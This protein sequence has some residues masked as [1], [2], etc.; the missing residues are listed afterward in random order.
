[1]FYATQSVPYDINIIMY[2]LLEFDIPNKNSEDISNDCVS[3]IRKQMVPYNRRWWIFSDP[4]I[5]NY[6]YWTYEK[7][8]KK[9]QWTW[10][11]LNTLGIV[12]GKQKY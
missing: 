8:K 9:S 6:I 2:L 3:S 4:Y 5:L 7:K 12:H 1:M 11:K 10:T